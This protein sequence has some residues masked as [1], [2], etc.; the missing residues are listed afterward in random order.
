[1]EC[2]NYGWHL[3]PL[4]YV[5]KQFP[6]EAKY[7]YS[8][9]MSYFPNKDKNLRMI[10]DVLPSDKQ[11]KLHLFVKSKLYFMYLKAAYRRSVSIGINDIST[12]KLTKRETLQLFSES[13]AVIDCPLVT[14]HGL[15]MRT[16]EVLGTG[17]K[18]IT[19]NKNIKKYDFYS[20]EYIFV[21]DED[22]KQILSDF[23]DK[24][25]T[26]AFSLDEKYSIDYFAKVLL[27]GIEVSYLK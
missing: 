20:D 7:D 12:N 1:V 16:F 9:V 15:T 18:L 2:K 22:T 17:V 27:H 25:P 26:A 3:L 6:A 13:K 21:V 19:T 4:F 8:G 5:N 10:L 23:F 11:S 24:K 14:Q